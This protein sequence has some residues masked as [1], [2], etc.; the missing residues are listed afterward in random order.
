MLILCHKYHEYPAV[1]LVD[2]A[3]S[4][5]QMFLPGLVLPHWHLFQELHGQKP[6]QAL[7]AAVDAGVVGY[8]S[9]TVHREDFKGLAV[10][11]KYQTYH[12]MEGFLNRGTPTHP[13]L[14]HFI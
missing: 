1:Q 13:K 7:S 10:P 3:F 8:L 14:D 12:K 5:L 11:P 2:L 9:R 4:R 6:L